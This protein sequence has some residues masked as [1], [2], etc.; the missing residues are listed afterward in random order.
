MWVLANSDYVSTR[1]NKRIITEGKQ[2]EEMKKHSRTNEYTLRSDN[3]K[4]CVLPQSLFDA[5]K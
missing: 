2:Y 4:V 5:V 1:T 3:N